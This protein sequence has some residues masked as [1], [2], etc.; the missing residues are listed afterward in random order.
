[1]NAP[2][3][4][5]RPRI[6][7]KDEGE[8]TRYLAQ[9]A[10]E[11]STTGPMLERAKIVGDAVR[12][13]TKQRNRE[14]SGL[15]MQRRACDPWDVA[16]ITAYARHETR[17][18]SGYIPDDAAMELNAVVGRRLMAMERAGHVES[19]AVL[20][21]YYGVIGARYELGDQ[22]IEVDGLTWAEYVR[23][24]AAGAYDNPKPLP[25]KTEAQK[26]ADEKP[27]ERCELPKLFALLHATSAGVALLK[28]A[29]KLLG[30]GMD[31]PAWE[32]MRVH[33]LL[34]GRT[35][36]D[37]L[38]EAFARAE[39]Q[40]ERMYADASEAWCEAYDDADRRDRAIVVEVVQAPNRR[41]LKAGQ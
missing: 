23:N 5:R 6:S 38:R 34:R 41:S 19:I 13:A 25:I 20:G 16:P 31:M 9:T 22:P 4:T 18:V 30:R 3:T 12:A 8:L 40:A 26:A 17:S 36:Y 2:A 24:L 28:Q 14:L 11:R 7:L 32:K 15:R 1:M 37:D 27:I 35:N 10:F 39:L 33:C 29:D 21:V